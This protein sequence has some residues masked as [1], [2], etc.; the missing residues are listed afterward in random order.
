MPEMLACLTNAGDGGKT[1]V[2]FSTVSMFADMTFPP[3]GLQFCDWRAYGR[4]TRIQSSNQPPVKVTAVHETALRVAR[5]AP[6]SG[7]HLRQPLA[8]AAA[9]PRPHRR[10]GHLRVAVLAGALLP[11]ARGLRQYG[12]PDARAGRCHRARRGPA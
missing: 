1:R 6:D 3:A 5:A 9:L 4:L 10:A 2:S 12:R 11:A 7:V 8:A